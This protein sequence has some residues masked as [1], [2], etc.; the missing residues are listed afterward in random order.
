MTNNLTGWRYWTVERPTDIPLNYRPVLVG[1]SVESRD[2]SRIGQPWTGLRQVATCDSTEHQPP[3]IECGCGVFAEAL[4]LHS[5]RRLFSKVIDFN[6]RHLAA[7][8]LAGPLRVVPYPPMLILGKIRL[9]GRVVVDLTEKRMG[10]RYSDE[11]RPFDGA[12][13][14]Y[15]AERGVIEKLW[16]T[17]LPIADGAAV[18]AQSLRREYLGAHVVSGLPTAVDL[19]I[20]PVPD[21]LPRGSRANSLVVPKTESAVVARYFQEGAHEAAKLDR[22]LKRRERNN[23]EDALR[24]LGKSGDDL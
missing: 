17:G 19:I 13:P 23:F 9:A 7:Q 4:S 12:V 14:E 5:M 2:N 15:L 18:I 6:Q 8:S 11:F 24:D 1:P 16:V 21:D 3:N 20:P 22:A 10:V